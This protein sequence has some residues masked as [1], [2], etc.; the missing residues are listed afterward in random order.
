MQYALLIYGSGDGWGQLSEEEQQAAMK[1]Y[2]ALGERPETRSGADLGEL[3]SAT[4]RL[5]ASRRWA[6]CA[7][8]A[9][10]TQPTS[11]TAER[12]RMW[13]AASSM[14]ARRCPSSGWIC[15]S[16]RRASRS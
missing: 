5:S 16:Y 14:S 7:V 11:S 1:D 12:G 3:S 4:T 13:A 2:M 10:A 15:S 8:R 6:I 9:P